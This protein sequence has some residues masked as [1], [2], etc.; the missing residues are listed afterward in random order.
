MYQFLKRTAQSLKKNYF[1][2]AQNFRISDCQI[3]ALIHDIE[4]ASMYT[5]A[6]I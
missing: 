3:L 6:E 5:E 2:I 1:I 4:Y